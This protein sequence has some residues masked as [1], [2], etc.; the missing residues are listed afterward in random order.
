MGRADAGSALWSM[1]HVGVGS[2]ADVLEV[3]A[4]STFRVKVN[5]VGE[6]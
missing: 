3:H 2:V 1:H 4:A 6:C 5:R